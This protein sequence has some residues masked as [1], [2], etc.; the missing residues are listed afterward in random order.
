MLFCC[1]GFAATYEKRRPIFSTS[2]A[3]WLVTH[4]SAGSEMSVI[5]YHE[6]PH[7]FP[8]EPRPDKF[9]TYSA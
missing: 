6:N 4:S 2:K 3:M 5:S 8:Q 9:D 7:H 1:M